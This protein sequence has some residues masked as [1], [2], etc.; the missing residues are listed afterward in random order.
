MAWIL[1]NGESIITQDGIDALGS[2]PGR[3]SREGGRP[4]ASGN[5]PLLMLENRSERLKWTKVGTFKQHPLF[6]QT[7][8][9]LEFQGL[10]DSPLYRNTEVWKY[11]FWTLTDLTWIWQYGW[12]KSL[13]DDAHKLW[14][15][16]FI[17][18]FR[19][20]RDTAGLHVKHLTSQ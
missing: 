18:R 14:G 7:V 20:L 16:S 2:C 8:F 9:Y 3:V 12:K 13:S 17:D 19:C 4:K 10:L 5:F 15:E 11:D 6:S 1:R